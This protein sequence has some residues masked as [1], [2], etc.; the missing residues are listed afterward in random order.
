MTNNPTNHPFEPFHVQSNLLKS[1]APQGGGE[2]KGTGGAGQPKGFA[3]YNPFGNWNVGEAR[4]LAMPLFGLIY[5]VAQQFPDFRP[6]T[7]FVML[8]CI[9]FRMEARDRQLAGVP[10]TLAAMRLAYQMSSGA[11]TL[12]G[13]AGIVSPQAKASMLGVPWVPMFFAICI[14]YLPRRATVTGKIMAASAI[15]MVLSGLLP[16]EGYVVIFA[17][18]QYTL[19]VGVL[20]GLV[21]D[22]SSKIDVHA[23]AAAVQVAR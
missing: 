3:D 6:L 13:A 7:I 16:G 15:S 14:F 5:Y 2:P 1:S 17:I 9:L 18:V 10:L 19:F 21:T 12:I 8:A 4:W 23:G 20:V 22:Y 11:S